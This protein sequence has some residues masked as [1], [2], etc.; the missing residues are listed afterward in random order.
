MFAHTR[1]KKSLI[2]YS[3]VKYEWMREAVYKC[4]G[5]VVKSWYFKTERDE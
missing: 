4:Q 3:D 1:D 2:F 5:Y